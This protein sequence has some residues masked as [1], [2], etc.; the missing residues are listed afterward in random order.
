MLGN[1]NNQNKTVFGGI[2]IALLLCAL[3]ALMPMSGFMSNDSA[4]VEFVELNATGEEDYFP[5]PD[6]IEEVEYEYD[7]SLELQGMRDETTKAYLTEDGNIAQLIATEPV[8]YRS[9]EGTWENI[10]LNIKAMP[11]GWSVTE[12]S[13][14]TL[15]G[16]EASSG[17]MVQVGQN[18]DPVI[19][20]LNPMLVVLDETGT[21]PQPY[22]SAPAADGIEVGGNV[23][24][25]PL[26][27][28]F[29]LDYT[30]D[31]TQVKQNLV[32]REA[33]VLDETAAWFGLSEGMRIPA[34]YALFFGETQLGE[35]I[36]K[37]QESLQ[38]R[39]IE[40]G[41]L[42]LDIP[43]PMV[44][45]PSSIEPYTGTF[46][47]Q[48]YGP[49][50]LLTTVVEASWLLSEDRIFPVGIDPTLKVNSN[51]GGYCY[52]YWDNCYSNI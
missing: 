15:F 7:P 32:V 25:Y 51:G 36:F 8:H 42:L 50:V 29:D 52:I 47:V 44:I 5:L 13:F 18:V 30:V 9:D 48:V 20:G 38:I 22:F 2:G 46:F 10:D 3:M 28:G 24:R 43:S 23:I 26:A 45:D 49:D 27:E 17:V 41:E 34:G 39:N 31:S 14:V 4:D 40:T 1:K 21:A 33:P 37:T 6:K 12:N 35:E 19:S 16:P 11:E